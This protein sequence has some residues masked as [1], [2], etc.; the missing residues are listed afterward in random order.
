MLCYIILYYLIL[1]YLIFYYIMLYYIILLY[2][3][4]NRF[5]HSAG[6]KMGRVDDSSIR[7]LVDS[8]I[9]R[10]VAS[11]IRR[12]VASSKWSVLGSKMVPKINRNRWKNHPKRSKIDPGGSQINLGGSKIDPGASRRAKKWVVLLPKHQNPISV[13]HFDAFRG[14]FGTRKWTKNRLKAVFFV[15][16]LPMRFL[17][18]KSCENVRKSADF[19][20]FW[21]VRRAIWICKTQV[22]MHFCIFRHFR[23]F[24][25]ILLYFEQIFDHF[26]LIFG[27]KITKNLEKWGIRIEVE[28]R[29]LK[30]LEKRGPRGH[31]HPWTLRFPGPGLLWGVGGFNTNNPLSNTPLGQRPG[32]LYNII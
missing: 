21:V 1:S 23:D 20:G 6:L 26:D 15:T 9:R 11:S 17:I 32:E 4:F 8:S 16:F 14:H 31:A 7:R 2:I 5:A 10:F 19:G 3:L 12:F 28:N 18:A 22:Q 29:S 13:T 24:W 30:K 25:R 27:P